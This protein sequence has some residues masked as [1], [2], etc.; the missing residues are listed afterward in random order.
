LFRSAALSYGSRAV[1]VILSGL[2]NDG[3]SGLRAIKACGGT[4]VVQHPFDAE[5]DAMP[6]AALEAVDPDH[7]VGA[8]ELA[9]VLAEVVALE[10]GPSRERPE[11]LAL[12]VHIAGGGRLGSETLRRIADPAALHCPDCN[13]VLSEVRG[14]RPLRY[15]CQIGHAQT[16][17]V[18]AACTDDVDEAMRVALRVMEERVT[19]VSSMARDARESG[20]AAMAEVYEARAEEFARY[21]EVL[22]TAAN[23]AFNGAEGRPSRTA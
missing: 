15:R 4:A 13:G 18:L 11:S 8:G 20:R 16:A 14:E 12:E 7:V 6:L 23:A 17:E 2:L 9:A 10:A 5:A 1:G 3:A 22:R 19:L 21:A